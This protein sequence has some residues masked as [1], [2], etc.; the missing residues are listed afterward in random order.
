M[1]TFLLSIFR[2]IKH[3]LLQSFPKSKELF[4]VY[5]TAEQHLARLLNSGQ[6]GLLKAA[7]WGWK[8]K[9]YGSID[10]AVSRRRRILRH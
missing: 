5:R 8:K 1:A 2:R 7:N 6:Q 4:R 9:P 10:E 3:R